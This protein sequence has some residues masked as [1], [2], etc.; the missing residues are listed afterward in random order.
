MAIHV[1]TPDYRILEI[2]KKHG[3][4]NLVVCEE[5]KISS[6]LIDYCSWNKIRLEIANPELFMRLIK[7]E[8]DDYDLAFSFGFGHIFSEKEIGIYKN[9]IWNIHPGELPKYRGRHPITHAILHGDKFLTITIH[10]IN[11]QI[12]QGNFIASDKIQ[13]DFSD[14]ENS[15]IEKAFGLLDR[16]LIEQAKINF[17]NGNIS[18]IAFAPYQRNFI[19][20][21]NIDQSKDYTCDYIYNAVKSQFDHGGINV[22]GEKYRR[23]HYSLFGRNS[24][25]PDLIF[26]CADGKIFLFK[27]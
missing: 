5:A 22:D 27:N 4:V 17:G 1:Y 3:D 16:S 14:T 11:E 18:P 7:E 25:N 10:Q 13:R 19:N 20:G 8:K 23:A 9:G 26:D 6:I 12:D 24:E 21:I 2:L 15:L